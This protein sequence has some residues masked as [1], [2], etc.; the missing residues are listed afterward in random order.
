MHGVGGRHY[1]YLDHTAD[2]QLHA[3]GWDMGEAMENVALAMFDYITELPGIQV[4]EEQEFSISGHDLPSLLY[5]FLD[6]WLYVF[7]TEFFVP[8]SMFIS[9]LDM[10][11][12]T[13]TVKAKGEKFDRA[14]HVQGTEVKAITY[15]NMQ[16]N[17]NPD[18]GIVD[19]YVIVDI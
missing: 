1:E 6:Q 9:A 4:V 11:T 10:Q 19:L 7:S 8:A 17:P 13:L 5:N 18:T 15:S 2:I 14:R 3:W 12:F 16:I